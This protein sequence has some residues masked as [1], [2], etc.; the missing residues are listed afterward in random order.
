MEGKGNMLRFVK[1]GINL[2]FL[3]PPKKTQSTPNDGRLQQ[4]SINID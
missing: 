1:N 3:C 4:S 2:F